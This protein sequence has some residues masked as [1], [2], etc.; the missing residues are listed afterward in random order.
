[1]I[2]YCRQ[3]TN[4]CVWKCCSPTPKFNCF[5][6]VYH[7]PVEVHLLPLAPFHL[8]LQDGSHWLNMLCRYQMTLFPKLW[9][10]TPKYN[11]F[12][13][14]HH[15][16]KMAPLVPIIAVPL[17]LK[18]VGSQWNGAVL[19]I[20]VHSAK[21]ELCRRLLS[22]CKKNRNTTNTRNQ[23]PQPPFYASVWP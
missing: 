16:L 23:S 22:P 6:E 10:S 5:H 21:Y 9:F 11:W 15:L 14:V 2:E 8:G 18:V 20:L 17:D 12:Y 3:I 19:G 13:N 1:M 4:Q 7:Q